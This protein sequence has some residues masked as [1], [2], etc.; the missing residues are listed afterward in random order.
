MSRLKSPRT[1][2]A[3]AV[4][5]VAALVGIA[6][7]PRLGSDGGSASEPR[8]TV[9]SGLTLESFRRP[10]TGKRELLVSLAVPRLNRPD[11]LGG[12]PPLVWLRC[13]DGSGAQ[14]SR[15]PVDWPLL[16]EEGYAPHIH[17]PADA[18][19]LASVRTCRLTGPGVV[20]EG[21]VSGRLPVSQ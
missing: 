8:R 2:F 9:R 10:D 11:L 18:R 20:F 4:V 15:L 6:V 21:R 17:Q 16:E 3:A 7:L 13:F 12:A 5:V 14:V 1:L 19:L